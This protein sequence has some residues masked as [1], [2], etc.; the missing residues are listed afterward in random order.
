MVK[1]DYHYLKSLFSRISKSILGK[2]QRSVKE[3]QF[4]SNNRIY[5]FLGLDNKTYS[6]IRFNF[7]SRTTW[8]ISNKPLK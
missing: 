5:P 7:F 2:K 8:V 4:G 3:Y 1:I 6:N